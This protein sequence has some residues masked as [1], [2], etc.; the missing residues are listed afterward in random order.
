VGDAFVSAGKQAALDARM[1][2]LGLRAGDLAESFIRGSGCGGQKLNK[3]SSCV[4]LRH[5]ASGLEVKCQRTRS[6]E[7][8]RFLARRELCD[9]LEAR[10]RGETLRRRAEVERIRRQK[11]RRSRRQ[12][13]RMLDGK[14]RQAEKKHGR[15]PVRAE[16]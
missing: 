14:H 11:R 12:R 2:A 10:A 8:N 3:T 9:A 1:R 6:R 16:E 4:H 7:L 15:A 5:A 13:E